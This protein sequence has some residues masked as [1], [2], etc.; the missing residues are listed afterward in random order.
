MMRSLFSAVS[1]LR[2]HQTAM[3]VIGNNISNVNTIGYKSSSVIFSD[4]YSQTVSEATGANA[5][6]G[7]SNAQQIGLGM[8]ISGI[9][10]NI[11]EGS[12]QSTGNTLDFKISGEGYFMIKGADGN[13]YYTRNGAFDLDN[14]GNLVIMPGNFVQ[15]VMIPEGSIGT[16]TDL[17]TMIRPTFCQI[18]KLTE[19][20]SMNTALTATA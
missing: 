2:N 5:N 11:T 7:G 3:D 20:Y 10:T 15:G 6:T 4:L 14:E 8:S 13:T 17:R 1:G 9:R 19:I 18:L 16:V 12:N